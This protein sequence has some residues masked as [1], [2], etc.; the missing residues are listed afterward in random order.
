MG[1]RRNKSIPE[2]LLDQLW[3]LTGCI[4]QFGLGVS[5]FFVLLGIKSFLWI[6][7]IEQ[8]FTGKPIEAMFEQF[9]WLL[10]LI[11]IIC[12]FF[13]YLFGKRSY[14]SYR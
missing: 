6:R 4:W 1:R 5:L 12:L 8:N 3:D 13:S 11:P 9:S 10:Y 14:A 7:G 2:E